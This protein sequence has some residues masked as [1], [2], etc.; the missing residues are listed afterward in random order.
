[1]TPTPQPGTSPA[2]RIRVAALYVDPRGCYSGLSG[3]DP[4]GPERDARLYSGPYPVVAHPPCERWG[5]FATG[6]MTRK[7]KTL[8]DDGGCFA[9]A[10]AAVRRWGGVLEHP[11]HSHAW[12]AHGIPT[13]GK[14]EWT[15]A[16][17]GAW[18]CEVEQAH[19]G[20]RARKRT[21]LYYVGP[22]P[23][24]LRWGPAPQRLPQRRLAERGYESA[25]RAG[26]IAMMGRRER[27]ATPIPFRDLLLSLAAAAGTAPADPVHPAPALADP[28]GAASNTA[29][30]PAAPD[31]DTSASPSGPLPTPGC[32]HQA[33]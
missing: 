2:E 30:C 18:T 27:A 13:P 21:W 4:W 28:A 5:R 20:H 14:G 16:G 26:I 31:A 33:G 8:G 7:N 25:R 17:E 23:P 6:S 15:P 9:A 1:M 32:P 22:M 19:Y 10:L 24:Q 12:A 29:A 3:V 11:A